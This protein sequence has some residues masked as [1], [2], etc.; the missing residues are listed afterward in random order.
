MLTRTP[1]DGTGAKLPRHWGD[2][3]IGLVR[4]KWRG[5]GPGRYLVAIQSAPILL[6]DDGGANGRRSE[7]A[8]P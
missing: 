1:A 4:R 6:R 3:K 2:D 8:G 7:K 5:A